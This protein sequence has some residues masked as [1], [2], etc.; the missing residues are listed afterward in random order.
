MYIEERKKKIMMTMM[1]AMTRMTII[2]KTIKMMTL[3][4]TIIVASSALP[5]LRKTVMITIIVASS[6]LPRIPNTAF[7]MIEEYHDDDDE[8]DNYDDNHHEDDED[9]DSYDNYHRS[10]FC[11]T[12]AADDSLHYQGCLA[13]IMTT[14]HYRNGT[15][16]QM[17]FVSLRFGVLP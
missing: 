2:M 9:D 16:P 6:A 8:G 4:I 11:I 13:M 5:K 12:K 14:H 10:I 1:K 3:M 17:P 7:E 15:S